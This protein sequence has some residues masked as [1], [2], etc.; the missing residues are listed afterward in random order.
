MKN[1]VAAAAVLLLTGCASVPVKQTHQVNRE[2]KSSKYAAP[3]PGA[4]SVEP[5]T[6]NQ[7]VK[8]RWFD[9]FRVHPKWFTSK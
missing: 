2:A 4:V 8:K 7:I 5:A 3:N 1:L 6:P 9:R